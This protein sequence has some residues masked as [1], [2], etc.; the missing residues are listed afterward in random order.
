MWKTGTKSQVKA[1][2]L[3][4][5]QGRVRCMRSRKPQ[6]CWRS[7]VMCNLASPA[8]PLI[9]LSPLAKPLQELG[10]KNGKDRAQRGFLERWMDL[11]GEVE[12][13]G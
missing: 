6:V 12:F 3:M 4:G 5:A 10:V 11:R 13:S 7:N 9:C 2:S 1:G 8:S